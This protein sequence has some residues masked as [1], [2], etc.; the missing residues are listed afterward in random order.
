M[1]YVDVLDDEWMRR[2][3][4]ARARGKID[5]LP[6][7]LPGWNAVCWDEG[8]GVGL[9]FGWHVT[10]G[11]KTG[12]GKSLFALNLCAEAIKL[13]YDIGFVSLEMSTA[14]LA[15]RMH[16][17]LSGEHVRSLEPGKRFDKE[18]AQ[19]VIEMKYSRNGRKARLMVVDDPGLGLDS[20]INDMTRMHEAGCRVFVVDYIQLAVALGSDYTMLVAQASNATRAFAKRTNSLTIALSQ[21]NRETSKNNEVPPDITGLHA[22]SFLEKDS[23]QIMLL[24]HSRHHSDVWAMDPMHRKFA[25]TYVLIGKNRHGARGEIPVFWDYRTLRMREVMQDEESEH[26]RVFEKPGKNRLTS[27]GG[28]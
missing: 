9:A 15:T 12:F 18:S 13:G 23:D 5:A 19:R 7:H 3:Y 14:Q 22:S 6:T 8:G 10:I 26:E 16:S 25:R 4:R 27:R 11:G 1:R 20:V 28:R 17:I 21:L 24:D 2:F